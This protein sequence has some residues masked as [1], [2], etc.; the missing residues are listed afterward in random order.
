MNVVA[1]GLARRRLIGSTFQRMAQSSQDPSGTNPPGS[2]IVTNLPCYGNVLVVQSCP[3]PQGSVSWFLNSNM[4]NVANA[5]GSFDDVETGYGPYSWGI[6]S[7]LDLLNNSTTIINYT[8]TFYFLDGP[9][10]PCN[11]VLGVTGLGEYTTATV[12]QPVTFRGEYD[13]FA[14]APGGNGYA[15]ANTTLDVCIAL[16]SGSSGT[17]VGSAYSI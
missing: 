11:L 17:V 8:V 3:A 10:N 6:G 2:W 9:P 12:S 16:P 7:W 13:L 15:S 4:A 1:L 14:S 5:Y